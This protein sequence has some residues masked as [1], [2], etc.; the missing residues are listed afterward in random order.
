MAISF[1]QVGPYQ[2]YGRDANFANPPAA[3]NAIVIGV[4]EDPASV[5]D[6][7]SNSYSKIGTYNGYGGIVS[8][9]VAEAVGS[10]GDSPFTV[11][12]PS[13][14]IAICA[15]EL[16]N[17]PA[18]SVVDQYGTSQGGSGTAVLT[19][20]LTLAQADEALMSF[21]RTNDNCTAENNT[22]GFSE[23][24]D[25]NTTRAY[26]K[27]CSDVGP[28]QQSVTLSLARWWTTFL[29][30]VKGGAAAG[31]SGRLIRGVGRGILR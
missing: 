9:W 21:I 16:E 3:G 24:Y 25:L 28:H 2:G 17:V 1:R 19:A 31:Y 5:T 18:S 7:G 20:Q 4:V 12:V 14:G 13:P 6:E 26:H 23:D 22:S 8:A 27:V 15:Y 10:G 11:Y 30:A 29:V